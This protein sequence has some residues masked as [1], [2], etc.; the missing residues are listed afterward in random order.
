MTSVARTLLVVFM[1]LCMN[2]AQAETSKTFS[3]ENQREETFNLENFLKEIR[4]KTEMKDSTCYRQEPYVQNV[5]RDVT[6]YRQ[7]CQTNPAH[8]ECRTVYDRVCHIENRY[9][10]ECHMERGPQQCRVVVHYRRECSTS[11]GGKQC[12]QV[13]GDVVCRIVRGE[14]KCEKI[15][16]HQECTNVPGRQDC[17]QVPYEERKCSEGPSRQV[18]NQ[19]NRPRE[20]CEN[21]SRQ[22]CEWIPAE[23]QCRSIPYTVNECKDETLYKQIP[24]ACKKDV[25]V[26]YEVIL[27]THQADIQFLFDAK[28]SDVAS[29]YTVDLNTQGG[30][31]LAAKD[32]NDNQTIAIVKKDVKELTRGDVNTIKAIY[33]VS[34]FNREDLF[35]V[36]GINDV[37]LSKKSMSFVAKGKFAKEKTTLAI[38]IVKKGNVKF[39]KVLESHQFSA[40][41]DGTRTL[42]DVDLK[43]LG[44]PNLTGLGIF[45][46]NYLV[47]VK[48]KLDTSNLG[49]VLLPKLGE[50]SAETSVEVEA[51]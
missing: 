15:P 47:N 48:L 34:L 29:E 45:N 38:K 10:Q 9:E 42:I 39:E 32:L 8:Q 5:C 17:R 50:V 25:Q 28:S 18:C 26:P 27:K 41:F 3:F 31:T 6:R 44:C 4:Y 46:K 22:L 36:K 13:P 16:P 1:L 21:R 37:S 20:V 51:Q 19:V 24:Y 30:L 7:E 12:R 35:S 40:K 33:N 14:N 11:G 2:F 23:Q 49:E 43:A